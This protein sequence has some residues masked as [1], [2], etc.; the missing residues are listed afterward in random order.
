[1]R[2]SVYSGYTLTETSITLAVACILMAVAVPIFDGAYRSSSADS[3]AQ[4]IA[5][6]L[7]Y[8]RGLAIGSHAPVLLESNPDGNAVTVA[9]GT[10]SARGPFYLPGGMQIQAVASIPDTPDALGATL[11]GVGGHTEM[12]FLDNGA[13]I[14]DPVSNNLCSGTFFLKHQDGDPASSRAV[15]LLGGTGRVRIWRYDTQAHAWK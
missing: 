3:A 4:L 8:A 1:M 11:L 7:S 13:V 14:D 6:Q 10:G 5:Q 9:S 2:T 12:T 15:T